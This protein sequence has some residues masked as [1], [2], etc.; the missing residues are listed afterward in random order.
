MHCETYYVV[1]TA[2]WSRLRV[3][4]SEVQ[5]YRCCFCFVKTWEPSFGETGPRNHMATGEHVI[6][7][8][9]GGHRTFE[10]TVMSCTGCNR[11][12]GVMDIYIFAQRIEIKREKLIAD[13]LA[14]KERRKRKREER[15]LVKY[16]PNFQEYVNDRENSIPR[17]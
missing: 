17:L 16:G 4:V 3:R 8:S 14:A 9:H 5:R 10:N 7:R 2:R 13:Q 15:L 11:A 12:R 1:K 6:P